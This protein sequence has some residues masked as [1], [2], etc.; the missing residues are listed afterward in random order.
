MELAEA[1]LTVEELMQGTEIIV[2]YLEDAEAA[3]RNFED[4]LAHFGST[5]EQLEVKNLFEFA[6]RKAKTQHERL[7]VRLRALGGSPS[8]AKSLLAHLLAFTPTVAQIG[9]EGAEKNTQHL[10]VVVAAAAAEMAMYESLAC[11]AAAAGDDATEQ[12]ARQLQTEEREDYELAWKLLGPSATAAFQTVLDRRSEEDGVG[13]IKKYLEDAIAAEKSFETQLDTF[14]KEGD[15][16]AVQAAFQQ[17]AVETRRQYERLTRRLE[18]LGG[19]TSTVKSLLANLFGMSPKVAQLGHEKEER[20]TQ[21]LMMAFAVENSELAL[22]ES[23]AQTAETAGDSATVLL[24]REIQ[25][26]EK[27]M[28]DKVWKL[29]PGVATEAFLKLTTDAAHLR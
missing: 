28:A 17:H 19:S 18:Q 8:Q 2:R 10:I 11:A 12:L 25:K 26:E 1:R 6:S 3:E 4:A 9:H 7:E 20:T 16:P 24:A 21:N 29:L 15:D 27:A 13:V 5:G 14:A 22:Y 23:L